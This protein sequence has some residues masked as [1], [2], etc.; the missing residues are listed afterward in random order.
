MQR[1]RRRQTSQKLGKSN[2]FCWR[3]WS[4]SCK[5]PICS[6]GLDW[7]NIEFKNEMATNC[8]AEKEYPRR[9]LQ[10]QSG[11]LKLPGASMLSPWWNPMISLIFPRH[12]CSMSINVGAISYVNM[13]VFAVA[14]N[15]SPARE[16][17]S[18]PVESWLK[19]RGWPVKW[20]T[21]I[22]TMLVH[23]WIF[24]L[25]Q[26]HTLAERLMTFPMT[27]FHCL[28]GPVCFFPFLSL[29]QVP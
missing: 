5:F 28:D 19:K 6:Q 20:K 8:I 12:S 23:W 14:V 16:T 3:Q 29:F 17:M 4:F 26:V 21:K 9:L 10:R 13:F 27:K 11:I 15:H 24:E 2:C 7:E 18:K 25:G 22:K 1:R